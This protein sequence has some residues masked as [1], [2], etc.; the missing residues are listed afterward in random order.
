MCRDESG[1][2][3]GFRTVT[4]S[5]CSIVVPS[6]FPDRFLNRLD[7]FLCRNTFRSPLGCYATPFVVLDTPGNPLSM[8]T[9]DMF[10]VHLFSYRKNGRLTRSTAVRRKIVDASLSRLIGLDPRKLYSESVIG[11][12]RGSRVDDVPACELEICC[13]CPPPRSMRCTRTTIM[14]CRGIELH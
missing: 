12:S 2:D 4:V 8:F 13:H 7:L 6:G 3:T 9:Q 11:T 10:V 5:D 14:H 1:P